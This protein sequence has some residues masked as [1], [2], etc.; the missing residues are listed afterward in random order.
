MLTTV[1]TDRCTPQHGTPP[2]PCN[3]RQTAEDKSPPWQAH[4]AKAHDGRQQKRGGCGGF[5]ARKR[6]ARGRHSQDTGAH[7]HAQGDTAS[8]CVG[9]PL[10]HDVL[11]IEPIFARR[12]G[13]AESPS[14][15]CGRRDSFAATRARVPTP[16]SHHK[17]SP[18]CLEVQDQAVLVR[19]A[20]GVQCRAHSWRSCR[21]GMGGGSC[22]QHKGLGEP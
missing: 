20:A 19:S 15:Q 18:D 16:A 6:S 3:A 14:R 17:G 12:A 2:T 21:V 8:G 10:P 9:R 22:A 1:A 7:H 5:G 13:V 4:R 11:H